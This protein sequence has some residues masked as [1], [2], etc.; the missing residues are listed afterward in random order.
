MNPWLIGGG[1]AALAALFAFGSSASTSASQDSMVFKDYTWVT[2]LPAVATTEARPPNP[3]AAEL[4]P[5]PGQA[6]GSGTWSFFPAGKLLFATGHGG[7][8][9][10]LN[11]GAQKGGM[12]ITIW[13]NVP[14]GIDVYA[15][16]PH[17][18]N[19]P[20]KIAKSQWTK[21]KVN[22]FYVSYI[23]YHVQALGGGHYHW[24]SSSGTYPPPPPGQSHH[25][26]HWKMVHPGY[27]VW[28]TPATQN[29]AAS[30]TGQ[31]GSSY[32]FNL[33]PPPVGNPALAPATTM[34]AGA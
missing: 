25:R 26:G 2:S 1:A 33:V 23:P 11:G 16:T 5:P 4:P 15:W 32:A 31:Y 21:A 20:A 30:D 8:Q 24:E 12:T 14:P 10:N 7:R 27:I 17:V 6:A 13:P 34:P 9:D 3:L 28:L 29:Q 18:G 19:T 22:G